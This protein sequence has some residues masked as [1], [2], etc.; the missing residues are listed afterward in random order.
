MKITSIQSNKE[1]NKLELIQ[2]TVT[3]KLTNNEDNLES[4]ALYYLICA[5]N[6]ME[7]KEYTDLDFMTKMQVDSRIDAA[8]EF[9]EELK[10]L[11]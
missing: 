6:K 5:I 2:E 8:I 9:L 7:N 11:K 3:I 1:Y 10:K 4:K